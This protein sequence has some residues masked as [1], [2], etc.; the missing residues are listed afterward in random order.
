[1]AFDLL[2]QTFNIPKH[3]FFIKHWVKEIKHWVKEITL[4]TFPYI[5]TLSLLENIMVNGTSSSPRGITSL[6]YSTITNNLKPFHNAILKLKWEID[7]ACTY[8]PI[9]WEYFKVRK[10]NPFQF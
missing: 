8:N 2:S 3:Y 4:Q 5:S 10:V 7:L 6:I 9:E 1:M